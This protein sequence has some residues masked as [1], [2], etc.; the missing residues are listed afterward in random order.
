MIHFKYLECFLSNKPHIDIFYVIYKKFLNFPGFTGND[1]IIPG[2]LDIFAG[3]STQIICIGPRNNCADFHAFSTIFLPFSQQENGRSPTLLCAAIQSK[4][5]FC[6]R[7]KRVY[8]LSPRWRGV[9][10]KMFP[11]GSLIRV[12]FSLTLFPMGSS[13]TLVP[14][15]RGICPPPLY[16]K[17]Q[18]MVG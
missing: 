6:K 9:L 11:K 8:P 1:V 10:E 14:M 18:N 16:L 12:L 3:T 7:T 4:A 13:Y 2:K 17:S 15:G 5:H